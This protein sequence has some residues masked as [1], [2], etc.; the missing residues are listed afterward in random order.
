MDVFL[1]PSRFEGFG[2]AMI[3]AQASG[4]FCVASDV[5]PESTD[6]DGRSVFLSLNISDEKWADCVLNQSIRDA[7]YDRIDLVRNKYD[8]KTAAH[9][10]EKLYLTG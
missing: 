8:S 1:F 5:L 6:V 7:S 4:L 2:M 9:I 10:M 3:E